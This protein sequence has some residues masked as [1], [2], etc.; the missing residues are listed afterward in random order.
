MLVPLFCKH[1]QGVNRAVMKNFLNFRN[2]K[3]KKTTS[4]QDREKAAAY[5][6]QN[7][8]SPT[9]RRTKKNNYCK[10]LTGTQ[11]KQ[12]YRDIRWSPE[13]GH[14]GSPVRPLTIR[15]VALTQRAKADTLAIWEHF[16]HVCRMRNNSK[17]S[18][19][20]YIIHSPTA[21]G[22]TEAVFFLWDGLLRSGLD[23]ERL[24]QRW[25]GHTLQFPWMTPPLRAAVQVLQE[26]EKEKKKK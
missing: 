2:T 24:Q 19:N 12:K 21:V 5:K 25:L 7:E 22:F 3:K 10:L 15:D 1:Y 20:K 13:Q 26:Q 16:D 8:A 6:H 9:Q 17:D 23:T 14:H 4:K 11:R 18:S